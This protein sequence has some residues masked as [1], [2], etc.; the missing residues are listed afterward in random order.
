[1][2]KGKGGKGG[3]GVSGAGA[4][5]GTGDARNL[6]ELPESYGTQQLLLQARDPHWVHACWDLSREQQR[7]YNALPPNRPI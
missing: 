5:A 4:G 6:T 2:G 7:R 1:M 3:K